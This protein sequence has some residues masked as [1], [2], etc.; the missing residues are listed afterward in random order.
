MVIKIIIIQIKKDE[1]IIRKDINPGTGLRRQNSLSCIDP[2]L[3]PDDILG[4]EPPRPT[5]AMMLPPCWRFASLSSSAPPLT[6]SFHFIRGVRGKYSLLTFL[7]K[8]MLS[9]IVGNSSLVLG[10]YHQCVLRFDLWGRFYWCFLRCFYLSH[11]SVV[12]SAS[13]LVA[14]H[15]A[16]FFLGVYSR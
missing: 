15:I 12:F 7:M 16:K 6:V 3:R 2:T 11:L 8:S 14:Y 4:L 1:N 9:Y 13:L 5:F 10:W